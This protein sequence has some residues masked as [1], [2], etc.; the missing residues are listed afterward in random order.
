VVEPASGDDLPG[1]ADLPAGAL[2]VRPDGYIC[3]TDAD[4]DPEPALRHWFGGPVG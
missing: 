4:P 3:W 2:L 1:P